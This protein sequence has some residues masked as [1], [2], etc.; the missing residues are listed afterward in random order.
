MEIGRLV[1]V[2]VNTSDRRRWFVHAMGMIAGTG[3]GPHGSAAKAPLPPVHIGIDAEFS[4]A[5]STSAQAVS[6]G[7]HL[8]AMEA[9]RS[10][11]VLG[12]RPLNVLLRDNRAVPSRSLENLNEFAAVKD[13]TAVFCGKF[14]PVAVEAAPLVHRE[15]L[16]YLDPWAAV[17][18]IV[19]NGHSPNYVFR[20]APKDSWAIEA[21]L[22][23]LD[24]RKLF[25]FCAVLPNT[26]WGRSCYSAIQAR[27]SAHRR[28]RLVS[29]QWYNWGVSSFE[30]SLNAGEMAKADAILFIGN[31]TEGSLLLNEMV[32]LPEH[33]R[34]P[35]VSHA[36]IT[37][38]DLFNLARS[39]VS[40]L[41]LSFV[42]SFALDAASASRA[43]SVF[44]DA[45]KLLGIRENAPIPSVVGLV[46]AYDLCQLLIRAIQAAH[47]T[48]RTVIRDA[49]EHIGSYRGLIKHYRKPF[50]R[51]RHEALTQS[52]V[53]LARFNS[54]GYVVRDLRV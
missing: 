26:A 23:A 3:L 21:I 16:I 36:G 22:V 46:Q 42:Q 47:T 24:R 41:D 40:S 19:A 51:D 13:L 44:R 53:F 31:E 52:D 45:R 7:V 9:N 33:K 50:T 15:R 34:L 38:G 12:G 48:D 17:D 11:G 18:D 2:S 35:I 10:G 6:A 14:S 39:G 8:A 29:S 49:L 25:S 28:A 5:N 54:D 20:L 43:R 4:H 1:S 37:G 32:L 27:V 30:R